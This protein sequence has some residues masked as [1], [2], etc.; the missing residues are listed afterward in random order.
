MKSIS[1]QVNHW[2]DANPTIRSHVAQDLINHSALARAIQ[3]DIEASL[4]QKVSKESITISLN[5][6]GKV[7]Q[8]TTLDSPLQYVGDIS[9]QTG[10]TILIYDI[11]DFDSLELPD[12]ATRQQGYYVSTR[13]IWHAS[14]ITTREIAAQSSLSA[15]AAVTQQNISSTTIRLKPGHIDV[16]GVC[17]GILTLLSNKGVNLQEVISTHNELTILTDQSNAETALA[18]LMS[19]RHGAHTLV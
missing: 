18:T 1:A 10:L 8:D 5:R 6:I 16:T 7:L 2:L 19:L 13:G 14:I 9:I 3:S 17:A 12:A 15:T 4:D 11:S